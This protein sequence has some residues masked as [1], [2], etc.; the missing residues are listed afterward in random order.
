MNTPAA[1][2]ATA[3]QSAAKPVIGSTSPG[4]GAV[5]FT[6]LSYVCLGLAFSFLDRR[7]SVFGIETL[8][9]LGWAVLG[10]GAGALHVTRHDAGAGRRQWM[11]MGT[12]GAL[13]ALFPGVALYAF[14]RWICLVLLIVMGARA[15]VLRTERDLYLTLTVI[16]AVSFMVATHM[17]ADWTLWFYLGPAWGFGAL[18]LAWNHAKACG[19]PASTKLGMTTGFAGVVLACALV[20]FLL[21]PRPSYLG[22]GFLPGGEASGPW[23]ASY[24]RG[25]NGPGRGA[26]ASGQGGAG[27]GGTPDARNNTGPGVLER[28]WG[29]LLGAMRSSAQDPFIPKWQR[30]VIAGMASLGQSLLDALAG[31]RDQGAPS[32]ASQAPAGSGSAG[33]AQSHADPVPDTPPFAWWLLAALLAWLL[34]R[35]RL[36]AG[37]V[38]ALGCS[39]L[40]ARHFPY[41]SMHLSARA[42]TWCLESLQVHRRPGQSVR[43]HW[44]SARGLPDIAMHW[45]H[46][47]VATYGAVRFGGVAAT[48]RSARLLRNDVQGVC[49]IAMQVLPPQRR[50]LAQRN[51]TP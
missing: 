50:R 16:F 35:M 41:A 45:A 27:G 48:A 24:A 10:F 28:H 37:V 20:L 44:L 34:Y 15:A 23:G 14:P 36:R 43:E 9:W 51:T 30:D 18:A 49:D 12:V 22:W 19:L 47:A 6:G 39:W 11:V 5:V 29:P 31:G 8:L 2:V 25:G 7:F 42:L 38:M 21:L 26:S 32:P 33:E 40:L 3:S 46:R 4:R 17:E 1:Q 13:L